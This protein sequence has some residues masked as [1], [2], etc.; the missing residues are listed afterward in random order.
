MGLCR[1]KGLDIPSDFDSQFLTLKVDVVLLPTAR[2]IYATDPTMWPAKDHP[3]IGRASLVGRCSERI[4]GEEPSKR[5]R[6]GSCSGTW[7][8]TFMRCSPTAIHLSLMLGTTSRDP[9]S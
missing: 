5:F 1:Y 9:R 3:D 8:W 6:A 7:T 2:H 4:R